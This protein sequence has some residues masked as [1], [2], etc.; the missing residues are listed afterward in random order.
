MITKAFDSESSSDN[1]SE[2]KQFDYSVLNG[3]YV[4]YCVEQKPKKKGH[5]ASSL[6]IVEN[7]PTESIS[8]ETPTKIT[9]SDTDTQN[10]K[11]GIKSYPSM[12]R[13]LKG[14]HFRE[15]VRNQ[16]VDVVNELLD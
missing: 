16:V 12:S 3:S 5:G 15:E 11:V 8:V 9:N 6:A 4:D 2:V 7:E 13:M 14:T 1:G 10:K